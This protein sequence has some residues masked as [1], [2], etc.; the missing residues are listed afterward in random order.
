MTALPVLDVAIASSADVVGEL[1]RHGALLAVDAT[2]TPADAQRA[3]ADAAALFALPDA[4]KDA[5]AIARSPCWRGHSRM[6]NERDWREQ[7]HFGPERAAARPGAEPFRRLQGP[8]RWPADPAWRARCERHVAVTTAAA[9]RLLALVAR[10]FGADAAAWLGGDPYVLC[11]HIRYHAQPRAERRRGVAA[12]VDFSLLTLTL[13]DDVGGLEVRA[14]DG[15][16]STVPP[17]GAAWLVVVGELLQFVTSNRL[18]ATPH[19][20]VNPSASRAR[21]SIPVFLNPSLDTVLHRALPPLAV[22]LPP[23]RDP[24]DHV[25]AVLDPLDPATELAFGPA[26]WARK[27]EN[28][29]CRSCAPA[30]RAQVSAARS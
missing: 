30:A 8:N 2:F 16:W 17:A 12:H 15:T 9:T 7:V 1:Q 20:V 14:P 28:G 27:G 25:H 11:K 19:R 18:L 22:P 10:A 29:W 5:L 4:A 6:H 21:G 26:E 3:L 24:A 13:Q 23:P